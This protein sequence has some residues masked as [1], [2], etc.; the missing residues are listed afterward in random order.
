M[1]PGQAK[2]DAA[3]STSS[4]NTTSNGAV[5]QNGNANPAVAGMKSSS[6]TTSTKWTTCNPTGG[7]GT[8]ATCPSTHGTAQAAVKADASKRYGNAQTAAQI[9]VS[10]GG[11]GVKLTGPGNSQP[12]KVSTCLHKTNPSGGVDVHAIKNG[13]YSSAACTPTLTQQVL[14]SSVCGSK[15]VTTITTT[16][17]AALHG[18][19]K[20]H[21]TSS[22]SS[23]TVVTP[24]GEVCTTGKPGRSSSRR[25]PT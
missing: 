14:A 12:H 1:A 3:A 13:G 23:S 19:G 21:V 24:T 8:A 22:T 10:R 15:S 4:S 11:S 9:A 20:H 16:A 5:Q 7:T 18:N 25:S 6:S 17:Q 2:Q